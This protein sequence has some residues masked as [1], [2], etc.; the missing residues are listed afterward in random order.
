MSIS[1][2]LKMNACLFVSLFF[3][4]P[5]GTVNK[6][7]Y[8]KA[9]CNFTDNVCCFY[10]CCCCRIVSLQK[11]RMKQLF[12]LFI[13]ATSVLRSATTAVRDGLSPSMEP[14]AAVRCQLTQRFGSEAVTK[15]RTDPEQ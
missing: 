12:V 8:L 6:Q 10:Y 11:T 15:I 14:S 4:V 2:I 13:K 7:R 1:S 5:K 9:Q 3:Q